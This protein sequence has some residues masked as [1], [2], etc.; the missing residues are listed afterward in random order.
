MKIS[1]LIMLLPTSYFRKTWDGMRYHK[2]LHVRKGFDHGQ[3]LIQVSSSHD[4]VIS[5]QQYQSHESSSIHVREEQRTISQHF[6]IIVDNDVF[7]EVSKKVSPEIHL[8][9]RSLKN[10]Y[11]CTIFSDRGWNWT[12][13]DE[14]TVVLKTGI[15]FRRISAF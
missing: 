7:L 1:R 13:F 8:I 3:P 2:T 14:S 11:V 5:C 10:R 15:L 4:Q 9:N 12:W 6:Y